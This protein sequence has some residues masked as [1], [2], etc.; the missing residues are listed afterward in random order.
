MTHQDQPILV[1]I[2]AE[3]LYIMDDIK[4]VSPSHTV[5]YSEHYYIKTVLLKLTILLFYEFDF[6]KKDHALF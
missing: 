3:G 6:G 5:V 4:Y 1:A 2:N